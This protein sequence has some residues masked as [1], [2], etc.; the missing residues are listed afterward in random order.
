LTSD[1]H[2]QEWKKSSKQLVQDLADYHGIKPKE[3]VHMLTSY[4][5]KHPEQAPHIYRW[6]CGDDFWQMVCHSTNLL[7]TVMNSWAA[8]GLADACMC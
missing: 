6:M 7:S 2:A 4:Q 3:I 8:A 5:Q 1:V